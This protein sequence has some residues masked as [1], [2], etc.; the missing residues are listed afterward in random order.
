MLRPLN[1]WRLS[2]VM[3]SSTLIIVIGA[4][5]SKKDFD[6]DCLLYCGRPLILPIY[7][8]GVGLSFPAFNVIAVS[9]YNNFRF[10]VLHHILF[11]ELTHVTSSGPPFGGLT[12]S[13]IDQSNTCGGARLNVLRQENGSCGG[14]AGLRKMLVVQLLSEAKSWYL[15]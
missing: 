10:R 4:S 6:K 13:D 8:F 7:A 11:S 3:R 9:S 5:V 2:W 14:K 15:A 1:I 12:V